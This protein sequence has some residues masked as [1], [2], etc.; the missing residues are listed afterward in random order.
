MSGYKDVHSDIKGYIQ[1]IFAILALIVLLAVHVVTVSAIGVNDFTFT[2][3]GIEQGMISQRVYS[4]CQADDGAVW[5]TTKRGVS[6]YNGVAVKNYSLDKDAAR[7]NLVGMNSRFV[8]TGDNHIYVFDISGRIFVYNEM[9]DCFDLVVNLAS[10]FSHDVLLNDVLKVGDR[11][12]LAMREGIYMLD[13]EHLTAVKRGVFT[14]CIIKT[15]DNVFLFGTKQGVMRIDNRN[16]SKYRLQQEKHLPYY[17]ESGYYDTV[18]K[19]LWLGTFDRGLVLVDK[20]GTSVVGDLP[21]NP[22]RSIIPYDRNTMLIG[23]DGYGVCQIGRTTSNAIPDILFNANE[24]KNGVLHG[25]GIYALLVDAYGNI[26]IG[27]Y[28]GGIDIA[29]PVGSTVAVYQHQRN[30][31]QSLLNDHVNCVMQW[32][33]E[34]LLM[35]TD[36]GIS[37]LTPSTGQ[38]RHFIRGMVVLSLCRTPDNR[39][40]AGTYGN[41]VF[42]LDADGASRQV[43]SVNNGTLKDDHVYALLYDRKGHLWMGCLD[44]SLTEKTPAGYRYYDIDN[45]Q[46]MALMADGRIAVGTA[47]GLKLVTP[48]NPNVTELVYFSSDKKNVN[49]YVLDVY[50]YQDRDIYIATDGGG[51]YV[52]NMKTRRCRQI[53]KDNGLP[54]NT[55]TSITMDKTHRLWFGTD[56]GLAFI[57]PS[58]PD[59]V[60][61]VNYCYGFEREYI[62]GAA[63]NL[64]NGNILFGSISGAVIVN[65]HRVQKLNYTARLSFLGAGCSGDDTP[66]FNEKLYKMLREGHLRL[67]YGQRTFELYF[68]CINLRNQYDIAYQYKLA[69]NEWSSLTD[70]QYIRFVNLEPGTHKLILR[71]VSKTSHIVLDERQLVITVDRPWWSSWW[72]WCV[73]ISLIALMFYAAWKVY[74][75][76]T[77]Y[78]RLIV[79]NINEGDNDVRSGSLTDETCNASSGNLSEIPCLND[80]P[81]TSPEIK[82][83]ETEGDAGANLNSAFVDAVT[84]ILLEHIADVD[85]TIDNLCSEMAMSRTLFYVKLKSYT[86]KSPQEFIRVV[87]LE[88]A[89]MLLR[90][91]RQVGDVAVMVG[92][93]NAKY[94][95]TVFKKY[96]GISPSKYK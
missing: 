84:K 78:M 12:W 50:I 94:F 36:D 21:H 38:W 15:E 89:S 37:L 73:Y 76:H 39:L 69:H 58:N 43:Y 23:V 5:W 85:F 4:L 56:Q 54:S 8:Q 24:G 74:N 64:F 95:S 27:S 83:S 63:V 26:V 72:M 77:R 60:V 9:Q 44:G 96:F 41:G 31:M 35:G 87:R 67:D 57:N 71:A 25:N 7:H 53:T 11:L 93:D 66:S 81:V 59:D 61:N 17:V 88:R 2:H 90:L 80:L 14:N 65:P 46:T 10:I 45:V 1:K 52:Y 48:G 62:R 91:G 86:G 33:D 40:L 82:T 18:Y 3:L 47:K 79:S 19:R 55:V 70:Q 68:E 20:N 34:D 13:K 42:E 30:N 51:V 16:Q 22:I 29:R 92:F 28:S 6:R 32:S 75:L 49:R